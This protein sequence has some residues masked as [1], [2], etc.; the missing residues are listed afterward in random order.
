M[1]HNKKKYLTAKE[2]AQEF[3][4]GVIS[5]DSV[6]RKAHAGIIPYVQMTRGCKMLFERSVMIKICKPRKFNIQ[7]NLELG[8]Y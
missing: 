6:R 3:F 1:S 7:P 8:G 5:A 4:D 2:V